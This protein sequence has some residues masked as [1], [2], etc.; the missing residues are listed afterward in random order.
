MSQADK[1]LILQGISALR[2][3]DEHSEAFSR[4]FNRTQ[5]EAKA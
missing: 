2:L 4:R 1:L 3:H 5:N